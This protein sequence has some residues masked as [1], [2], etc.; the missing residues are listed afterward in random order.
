MLWKQWGFP[1][2]NQ[3]KDTRPLTGRVLFVCQFAIRDTRLLGLP[4]IVFFYTV[5]RFDGI[6]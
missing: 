2:K 5:R 6:S 4:E 1:V 3:R